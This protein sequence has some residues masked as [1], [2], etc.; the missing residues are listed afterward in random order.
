MAYPSLATVAGERGT[1]QR[2]RVPVDDS[3]RSGA[4]WAHR[5][6]LHQDRRG[7]LRD[8]GAAGG[9]E[10]LAQCKPALLLEANDAE[11]LQ[12]QQAILRPLGYRFTQPA[13]FGPHN[14]LVVAD[15]AAGT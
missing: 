10:L 7:R 14:W 2:L 5:R 1:G 3:T 12:A 15:G 9:L 13:G 11:A 8:A 4:R 6:A